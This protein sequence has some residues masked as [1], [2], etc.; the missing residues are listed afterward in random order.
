MF[1][2]PLIAKP[3][4]KLYL[5]GE[6]M[7]DTCEERSIHMPQ[8]RSFGT[9]DERPV[10]LFTIRTF[11]AND[12]FQQWELETKYY[13][14]YTCSDLIMVYQSYGTY[15]QD[16][17]SETVSGA[18]DIDFNIDKSYLLIRKETILNRVRMD[19][20]CSYPNYWMVS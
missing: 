3:K 11:R 12:Y 6:W 17:F 20:I 2:H 14:D 7:S 19:P 9:T 1:V 18:V 4:L 15:H 16:K 8:T 5:D 13:S 10:Q